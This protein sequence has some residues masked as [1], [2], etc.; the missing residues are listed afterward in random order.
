MWGEIFWEVFPQHQTV[1]A[2][3]RGGQGFYLVLV[4]KP[5]H[6][7][8][9]PR[10]SWFWR[11]EGV[12][13]GS[14]GL[15]PWEATGEGTDGVAVEAPELKGSCREVEGWHH[16]ESPRDAYWWKY[17]S[18]TVNDPRIWG[19]PVPWDGQQ[20]HQQQWSGASQNL[21]KELYVLRKEELEMWP[22]SHGGAQKFVSKSQI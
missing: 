16:E 3:F 19:M 22:K 11:H 18:V 2:G 13:E 9:P 10:W 1:G 4:A 12:I 14:W 7:Q 21:D 8:E 15:I 5:G 17:N 6:V 20:E